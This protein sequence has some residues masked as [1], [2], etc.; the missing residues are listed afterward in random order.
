VTGR[1]GYARAID[2]AGLTL[3]IIEGPGTGR[4]VPLSRPL[5]IGR[6][7][8]SDLVLE[9]GQ[10]SRHHA[11]V[12]PQS[13]L[14]ARVEDLG[15]VNGTFVNDSELHGPAV[16]DAG[17]RLLIGVT[18]IE[19]HGGDR[20]SAVIQVPPALARAPKTPEYVNP[21]VIRIESGQG[22]GSTGH[23]ELDRYLDVRVR[24]RAALAPVALFAIIVLAL[25]IYFALR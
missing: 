8:D 5:L 13:D 25:I 22:A 12:T 19:V 20:R 7:D 21:D 4:R 1:C 11:R 23:P 18:V 24:R 2:T 3:E 10:A 9:D 14:T 17:D 16:L 15:S 6:A